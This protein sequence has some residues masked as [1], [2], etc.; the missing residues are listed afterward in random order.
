MTRLRTNF[1]QNRYQ[2]FLTQGMDEREARKRVS[3]LLGHARIDVTYNTYRRGSRRETFLNELKY[4][5]H[6]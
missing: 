1:A 6:D 3:E 4:L 5:N 2:E